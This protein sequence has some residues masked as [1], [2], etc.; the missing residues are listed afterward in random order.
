M[1]RTIG[2]SSIAGQ[3]LNRLIPIVHDYDG[4]WNVQILKRLFD[5]KNIVRIIF[6][7]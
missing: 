5:Q 6:G 3:I 4:I 2:E 1:R 7:Q